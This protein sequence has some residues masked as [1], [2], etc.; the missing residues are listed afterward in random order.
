[1]NSS[2]KFL[3]PRTTGGLPLPGWPLG[4]LALDDD[5]DLS[6]S[7]PHAATAIARA[8]ASKAAIALYHVLYVIYVPLLRRLCACQRGALLLAGPA[9]QRARRGPALEKG[10]HAV[11]QER[12]RRYENRRS[13]H[14]FE[15]VTGLVRYDVAQPF[16]AGKGGERRR[17]HHVEGRG[18]QSGEDQRRRER[19]LDAR[20]DLPRSEA[21]AARG[22]DQ[23]AVDPVHTDVRVG[24]DDRHGE[25]HERDRDV[26]EADA[27]RGQQDRDHREAGQGAADVRHVDREEAAAVDVTEPD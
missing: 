22:L 23:I 19:H 16:A 25:D 27:D 20:E 17:G 7:D 5:E 4:G 12:Q 24:E 18:A 3:A 26:P 8:T 13:D 15:L 11:R 2:V 6:S 1:M 10:E 9:A 14:P 21:H